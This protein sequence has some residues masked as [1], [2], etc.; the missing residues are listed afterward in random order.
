V[1]SD[2]LNPG[3]VFT[4]N[5]SLT[6]K[7]GAVNAQI[8]ATFS[9]ETRATLAGTDYFRS[10]DRFQLNGNLGYRWSDAWSTKL[11]A[12]WTFIQRNEIFVTPPPGVNLEPFNSNGQV[13]SVDLSTS[14]RV[15][16]WTLTP[17]ASLLYRDQ[18]AYD[19]VSFNFVPA[20][21]TGSVGLGAAYALT[22]AASLT[23]G[24]MHSWANESPRGN[25]ATPRILTRVWMTSLG[26]S[27]K[28]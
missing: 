11:G 5:S 22:P 25:P 13:F 28:F 10:G 6:W 26:G 27:V 12:S 2:T 14:Y 20:K 23:A 15:G 9:T 24:V 7:Q 4:L 18:N 3:D 1:N 16:A 8:S 21:T 17:S 19:P